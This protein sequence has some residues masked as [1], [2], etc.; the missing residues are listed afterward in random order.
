M[1]VCLIYIHLF[2]SRIKFVLL[3]PGSEEETVSKLGSDVK[4]SLLLMWHS[5]C[6]VAVLGVCYLQRCAGVVNLS[7]R[8]GVSCVIQLFKQLHQC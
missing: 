1:S 8:R 4:L 6:T 7:H 5:V 3:E 2:D